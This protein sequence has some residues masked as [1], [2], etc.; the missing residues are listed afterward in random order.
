[1]RDII[2]QNDFLWGAAT[3][4]AQIEGAYD[5][6]GKCLS[7][8]DVA[9]ADKIRNGDNCHIA[10]DHYHRYK[11]DVKLM[12]EMGL[13]SYRFSISWCRIVPEEGRINETGLQFYSDLVD[14]LIRNGIEPLVTLYHWD[15]P[16]WSYEK[17]GW[18]DHRIIDDFAFYVEAV[19]KSLS[20]RVRYWITFNEPQ[21]FLMN[22]YMQGV[23]APF[24]RKYLAMPKFS[25]IFMKANKRAVE[26]IR[27]NA[28]KKPLI[29]LAYASGAFIPDDE[30]DPMSIQE[31]RRKS[32]DKGTMGLMNNRWWM[33]PI[34]LGKGVS[35]FGIYHLSN[36]TAKEVKV[37][38][39]F[40]GINHY[41]AFNY[42]TYGGD[43]TIDKT[44]LPQSQLGWVMDGKSMYW[45]LKFIYERYKLPIMITE[46]G[47]ALNDK[48]V[49]GIVEDDE[50][51]MFVDDY[52]SNMKKAMKEGVEV[53]GYHYWSLMDN[54]EWTE[55]YE[56]R[57]GLIHVDYQTMK[58]TMKKSAYHYRDIIESNGEKI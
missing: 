14:E 39:D 54:F 6:G 3:A 38:F 53:L 49:N 44:R 58:R 10:C 36:K 46:N 26:V 27:K 37:D 18:L 28:I 55:G 17:G 13:K 45:T 42:A 32:F 29:G 48:I 57:F 30:N 51:I 16:V 24:K 11:E 9:P 2:I 33:D 40:I 8:W 15:L 20:D 7:I 5:E 50:R 19:V 21:C 56:P 25:K 31:A 52:L 35:A 12:K 1:M 43:K 4:A 47:V 34:I 22:G 23:H 41:E